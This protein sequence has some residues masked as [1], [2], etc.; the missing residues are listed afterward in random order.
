MK[1]LRRVILRPALTL[2]A[3]EQKFQGKYVSPA[4]YDRQVTRDTL[5]NMPNGE[6]KF[7]FLR[8]VL[9]SH[10]YLQEMDRT[11]NSLPFNRVQSSLRRR[12]LKGS[13][14]NELVLG[15]L[16]DSRTGP[17]PTAATKT[18]PIFCQWVLWPLLVCMQDLM[19][20]HLPQ[21]WEQQREAAKRNGPRLMG[22]ELHTL[23]GVRIIKENGKPHIITE[24]DIPQPIVSTVTVN[25]DAIFRAHA[26]AK[27]ETGL[28]CMT[29]FGNFAGG[30]LCLPRFRLA[31]AIRPGDLLIV[32]TNREQH[33]NIAPLAGTRISVVAYLRSMACE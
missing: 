16:D 22:A 18:C 7:V 9:G 20:Q 26:D 11:F 25:K 12:A 8:D 23:V 28:A 21:Q 6:V 1:D 17:R 13:K 27:N 4:D 32:D 3:A 2:Q 5:G 29:T 24:Q 33:G 14:G 19:R 31:F 30:D 10:Q 15:W